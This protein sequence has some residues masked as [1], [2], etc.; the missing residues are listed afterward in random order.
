MM[1]FSAPPISTPTT[2][3]LRIQP[4]VRRAKLALHVL[5]QNRIGARHRHRCRQAARDLD[6]EARARQHGDRARAAD[7]L[8]DHFRHAQQRVL[9][10]ALRRAHNQR[11]RAE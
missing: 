2:S 5:G 1:F 10:D 9:L 4:E 7:F 3:V 6:R 8:R 11:L